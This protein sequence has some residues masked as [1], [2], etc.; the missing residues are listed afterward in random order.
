[1]SQGPVVAA[2]AAVALNPGMASAAASTKAA[3]STTHRRVRDIENMCQ[4]ASVIGTR[5]TRGRGPISRGAALPAGQRRPTW[6]GEGQVADVPAAVVLVQGQGLL[7]G[8]QRDGDRD[9]GIGLPAAGVRDV[10][11]PRQV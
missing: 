1:M 4:S 9:G 6:L 11:V 3:A 5:G 8:R 7:P 2:R 10:D